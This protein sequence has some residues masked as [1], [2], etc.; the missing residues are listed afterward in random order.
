ML[1]STVDRR[2]HADR[3]VDQ[4]GISSRSEH[5]RE[6]LVPGAV[7]AVLIMAAP[8]RLPRPELSGQIPPR[9]PRAIPPHNALDRRA[10]ITK[11]SAALS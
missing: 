3:P 9:A 10:V 7:L 2:V 5:D 6:D 8:Y 4:I 11:R 1:M